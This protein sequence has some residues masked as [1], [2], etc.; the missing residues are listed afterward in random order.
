MVPPDI[1]TGVSS[2]TVRD[3]PRAVLGIIFAEAK[4]GE[5]ANAR[6]MFDRWRAA[7]RARAAD[8]AGLRADILL[9]EVHLAV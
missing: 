7:L 9:V 1:V 2:R 6:Q 8:D 3:Q 4:S 5:I